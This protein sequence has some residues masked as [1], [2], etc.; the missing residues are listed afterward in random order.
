[1]RA[2]ALK[3]T[4]ET[5][6]KILNTFLQ[7]EGI[8]DIGLMCNLL[9]SFATIQAEEEI[10]NIHKIIHSAES[11]LSWLHLA[12]VC[13][14]YQLDWPIQ[15][16]STSLL[17]GL[18]Y[19]YTADDLER[20]K[21]MFIWTL[22]WAA[23]KDQP[24]TAMEAIRLHS[25]Y[26]DRN[27]DSQTALIALKDA[28]QI[29]QETK[30][31]LYLIGLYLDLAEHH[32]F[33]SQDREAQ[34]TLQIIRSQELRA[35]HAVRFLHLVGRIDV[36]AKRYHTAA[37]QFQRAREIATKEGFLRNATDLGLLQIQT[38]LELEK[39]ESASKMHKEIR[40]ECTPFPKREEI[41]QNLK[42]EIIAKTEEL[43][44]KPESKNQ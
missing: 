25:Q 38:L 8:R 40:D 36:R 37:E 7:L 5:I 17:A 6:N 43:R 33:H 44:Y 3:Q 22:K 27:Q 34:I 14:A 15:L 1:M 28:I 29:A 21:N 11:D 31:N 32:V 23:Q 30:D 4:P 12:D 13:I 24:R 18:R 19:L 26:F 9:D 42:K 20:A 35:A 16:L 2:H 10:R 41:W 39:L